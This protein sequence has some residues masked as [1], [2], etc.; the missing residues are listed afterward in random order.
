MARH[1]NTVAKRLREVAKK[2]KAEQK[3]IRRREKKDRVEP[4]VSVG[5]ANVDDEPRSDEPPQTERTM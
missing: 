2:Q 5:Y 4:D 3:N 1:Q